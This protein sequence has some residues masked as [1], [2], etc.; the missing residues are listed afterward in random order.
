ME[1][2]SFKPK[3]CLSSA[4]LTEIFGSFGDIIAVEAKSDASGVLTANGDVKVDGF[5]DGRGGSG[6][7]GA[8]GGTCTG[9]GV[10][11]RSRAGCKCGSAGGEGGS[12]D[13]VGGG[14]AGTRGQT[15]QA[16]CGGGGLRSSSFDKVRCNS[17]SWVCVVE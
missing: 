3:S 8:D 1:T 11:L 13:V 2:G 14:G 17:G 10:C 15:T 12:R 5:G 7:D 16:S 9:G 6:R 4:Q